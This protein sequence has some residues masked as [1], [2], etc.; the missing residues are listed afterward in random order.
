MLDAI[1]HLRIAKNIQNTE[2]IFVVFALGQDGVKHTTFQK[3]SA[4]YVTKQGAAKLVGSGTKDPTD[5]V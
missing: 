5:I 2:D 1:L 4:F 3:Q